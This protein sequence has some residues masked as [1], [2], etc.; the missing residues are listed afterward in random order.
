MTL[1]IF[2]NLFTYS[3]FAITL[4]RIFSAFIFIK[5]ALRRK[6]KIIGWMF[7]PEIL[8]SLF[9]LVGLYTQIAVIL[10]WFL[11]MFEKYFDKKEGKKE[12]SGET[13]A[14]L[15]VC[16]IATLFLGPGAFAFDL[17]L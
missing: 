1:S 6:N 7:I 9:L 5:I 13:L 11:V 15:E 12:T 10:I 8:I 4:I 17:P 3:I 16:L 14:L 2:P